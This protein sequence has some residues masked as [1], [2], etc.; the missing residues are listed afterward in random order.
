MCNTCSYIIFVLSY[1]CRQAVG[2]TVTVWNEV[3]EEIWMFMK[4][5]SSD[6]D[7]ST[8]IKIKII[9]VNFYL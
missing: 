5:I 2:G 8:V 1:P 4:E 6:G 7:V 3:R 9:M